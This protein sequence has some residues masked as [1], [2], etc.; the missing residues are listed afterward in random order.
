MISS[1][2]SPRPSSQPAKRSWRS[3]RWLLRDPFV[4]RVADEHVAEAERV[5]DRLVRADQ[6][7]A[8][9]R[10][11]PA[12]GGRRPS[13]ASSPS[14][15]HSKSSPMTDA[16]STI[17]RSVLG[18]RVEPGGEERLDRRRAPRPGADRRRS[19]RAT[20]RRRAG[21]LRRRRGYARASRRRASAPPSRLSISSSD[22]STVSGSSVIASPL[23]AARASRRSGRA[24]QKRSIGA[25]RDQSA[26]CSMRSSSG[27]SAQ[28][29]SSKTSASGRCARA[30]LEPLAHRP[31][32]V[33]RATPATSRAPCSSSALCLPV[34]LRERPVRDALAVREAA[35]DEHVGLATR[36]TSPPRAPAA[37]CRYPAGRTP[38][39]DGTLA[40]RA[41]RR[42]PIGRCANSSA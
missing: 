37:S 20:A 6:L 34:D 42:T 24:R 26:T 8:D 1:N 15:S 39:R 35:P 16:R 30:R 31:G 36:A 9:E 22:S 27:G 7:L 18:E 32:D 11:Q 2:S 38:S 25:S 10:G 14:A 21:C 3:A 5:V 4:S 19:S 17:S 29:M 41:P 33:F 23:H 12:P 28:W 40:P 13:G